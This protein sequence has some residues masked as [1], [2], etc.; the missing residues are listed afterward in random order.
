M[1]PSRR[2]FTT[3]MLA[4][5]VAAAVSTA[6]IM[7][8]TA[9]SA[10]SKEKCF[11]I[12]KAGGNDCAAGAGTTCAGTSR[13]DYQGNAWKF[14]KKGTCVSM[15]APGDRKGSLNALKRDIPA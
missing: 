5:A 3:T 11:G 15:K 6:A 13:V 7:T 2:V 1:S 14:V 8:S 10:A 4:S 12:A 9:A